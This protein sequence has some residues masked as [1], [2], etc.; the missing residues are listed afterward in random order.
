MKDEDVS[1]CSCKKMVLAPF[2]PKHTQE[3]E[4]TRALADTLPWW[5]VDIPLKKLQWWFCCCPAFRRRCCVVGSRFSS[6]HPSASRLHLPMSREIPVAAQGRARVAVAKQA[7]APECF[8][9]HF[10]VSW[11]R[12]RQ[13]RRDKRHGRDIHEHG[14]TPLNFRPEA[15]VSRVSG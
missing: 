8:L 5:C 7:I 3:L 14:K 9:Q 6:S 15:E 11:L 4:A 2:S 13:Q 10:G 12:E 1:A